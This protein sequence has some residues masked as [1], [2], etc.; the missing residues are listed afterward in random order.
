MKIISILPHP[1][2]YDLY[3]NEPRPRINWDTPAGDWVGI[4]GYDWADQIGN[5]ILKRTDK[6]KYEVW[7]PDLRA[8]KIYSHTFESG[9][10]HKLFPA[11]KKIVFNGYK[12]ISEIYSKNISGSITIIFDCIKPIL[13]LVI[14]ISIPKY[15][16]LV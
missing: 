5:E 4:W 8:D 12:F 9:L 3:K 13:S 6:F 7:Q 10:K 16:A 11:E 1:P 15:S 14:I 2:A